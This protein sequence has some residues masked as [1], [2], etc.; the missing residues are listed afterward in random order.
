V[1]VFAGP[2]TL[3]AALPPYR[4]V[5]DLDSNLVEAVGT[6]VFTQTVCPTPPVYKQQTF[7][8]HTNFLP[9][10]WLVRGPE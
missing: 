8:I 4:K 1:R 9:V 7:P 6:S 3:I 2:Q 5:A 10:W